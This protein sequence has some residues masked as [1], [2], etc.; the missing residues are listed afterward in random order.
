MPKLAVQ[1]HCPS[2]S[3]SIA[4]VVVVEQVCVVELVFCLVKNS[5]AFCERGKQ[6]PGGCCS[7]SCWNNGF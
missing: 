7:G 5:T 1:K 2:E 3:A 4:P 6:A